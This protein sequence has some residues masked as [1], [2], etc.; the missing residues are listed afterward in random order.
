MQLYLQQQLCAT[1]RTTTTCMVT[2][3]NAAKTHDH[4]YFFSRSYRRSQMMIIRKA[5]IVRSINIIILTTLICRYC[6]TSL[7]VNYLTFRHVIIFITYYGT[8]ARSCCIRIIIWFCRLLSGIEK[9]F[10]VCLV[11]AGSCHITMLPSVW[12]VVEQVGGIQKD[13]QYFGHV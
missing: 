5:S 12:F 7:F 11:G 1:S 4:K 6:A 10:S 9:A 8:K 2:T 3:T 13:C